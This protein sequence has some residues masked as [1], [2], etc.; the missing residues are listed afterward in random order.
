MVSGSIRGI[1]TLLTLL[2]MEKKRQLEI[3]SAFMLLTVQHGET[4]INN[5]AIV[6]VTDTR[7]TLT[8]GQ[9]ECEGGNSSSQILYLALQALCEYVPTQ[10]FSLR[11]PFPTTPPHKCTQVLHS[12]S[13]CINCH[14]VLN[15]IFLYAHAQKHY[16]NFKMT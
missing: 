8:T 9:E 5:R 4:D 1:I 15:Q 12:V 11:F 14:P 7:M 16:F 10:C 13:N 6:S 3:A 2:A